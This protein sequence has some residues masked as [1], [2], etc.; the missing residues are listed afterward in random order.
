MAFDVQRTLNG[1]LRLNFSSTRKSL[2]SNWQIRLSPCRS[3]TS[4]ISMRARVDNP[5]GAVKL[6]S[7]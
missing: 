1:N 2:A 3:R 4:R 6:S 7:V 5:I